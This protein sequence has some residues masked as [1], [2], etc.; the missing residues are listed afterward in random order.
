MKK[1]A[2]AILGVC[3]IAVSQGLWAK[4][5]VLWQNKSGANYVLEHD[6]EVLLKDYPL[7]QSAPA[8]KIVAQADFNGDKMSDLLW[9][10]E[11]NGNSWIGLMVN[12]EVKFIKELDS[13]PDWQFLGAGDFNRDGYASI[14]WRHKKTGNVVAWDSLFGN[15]NFRYV[16]INMENNK[17]LNVSA[18]ADFNADGMDDILWR[19]NKTGDN[20]LYTQGR[21]QSLFKVADINWSVAAAG[22][23][24]A[25]GHADLFWRNRVTGQNYLM[26]LKNAAIVAER[27]WLTVADAKWQPVLAADFDDDDKSDLLWHNSATGENYLFNMDGLKIKSDTEMVTVSDINWSPVVAVNNFVAEKN[28]IAKA[29]FNEDYY[30]NYREY[31]D[32]LADMSIRKKNYLINGSKGCSYDRKGNSIKLVIDNCY[33][34]IRDKISG[35]ADIEESYIESDSMV[36]DDASI[37]LKDFSLNSVVFNGS[38]QV[39]SL[40]RGDYIDSQS[41]YIKNNLEINVGGDSLRFSGYLNRAGYYDDMIH[42]TYLNGFA[43]DVYGSK[44]E[45]KNNNAAYY[46]NNKKIVEIRKDSYGQW[47][48]SYSTQINN[49]TVT[50]TERLWPEEL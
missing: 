10:D 48:F 39:V 42:A 21:Y 28:E 19:N 12:G 23:F 35:G 2:I 17:E 30:S 6:S 22:D 20:Y 40:Y 45:F 33:I 44:S 13:N 5:Q 29:R 14:L 41:F 49:E 26:L 11:K 46:L 4:A 15:D 32:I 3:S 31:F 9:L 1:I 16:N 37:I 18:I 36:L 47:E 7:N 50:A 43:V 25:D 34:S 38:Y 24:N 27:E 8:G